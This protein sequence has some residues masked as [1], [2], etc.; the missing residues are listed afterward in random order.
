LLNKVDILILTILVVAKRLERYSKSILF[1]L[2][3]LRNEMEHKDAVFVT[4]QNQ[5]WTIK[6]IDVKIFIYRLE[7]FRRLRLLFS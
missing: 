1:P 2:K 7:S 3:K 5:R 4:Q 6:E